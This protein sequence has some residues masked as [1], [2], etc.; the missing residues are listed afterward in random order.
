MCTF[1]VHCSAYSALALCH[2]TVPV[3]DSLLAITTECS[4]LTFVILAFYCSLVLKSLFSFLWVLVPSGIAI[5]FSKCM[6]TLNEFVDSIHT[7]RVA[8][9]MGHKQ[10]QK[11]NLQITRR[12]F[13]SQCSV[14]AV[15]ADWWF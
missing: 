2:S 6:R 3:N 13:S 5:H 4:V 9:C 11:T 14:Y 8:S 7:R 12:C 15:K 1:P 10:L